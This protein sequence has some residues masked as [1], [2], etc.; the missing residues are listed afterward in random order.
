MGQWGFELLART[1]CARSTRSDVCGR[2]S[3]CEADRATERPYL[4]I[5]CGKGFC[6]VTMRPELRRLGICNLKERLVVVPQIY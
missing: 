5:R 1:S 2:N 6:S 3:K 4:G